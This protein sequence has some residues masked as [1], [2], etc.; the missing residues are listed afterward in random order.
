MASVAKA[1][2]ADGADVLTGSS[3]SVV[4]A[5]GVAKVRQGAVVRD[6]MGPK[7]SLAPSEVVFLPGLQLGPGARANLTGI[8]GGKLGGADLH[9]LAGNNGEKIAL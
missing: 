1:Y 7:S 8:R 4:G 5:I 6:S 9:D 2:V 3:Q